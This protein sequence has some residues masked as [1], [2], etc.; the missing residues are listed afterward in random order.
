MSDNPDHSLKK[1]RS[2]P[3]INMSILT[4]WSVISIIMT[5][6]SLSVLTLSSIQLGLISPIV[7]SST[8]A[9]LQQHQQHQHEGRDQDQ[10]VVLS[11]NRTS[12]LPLTL[13]EGISSKL[14]LTMMLKIIQS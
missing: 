9:E 13:S 7:P 12:M 5:I 3:G 10:I 14:L 8:F 4:T 1:R 2:N 11:L 6:V